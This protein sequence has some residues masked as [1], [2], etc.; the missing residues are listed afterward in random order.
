MFPL[1]YVEHLSCV[2]YGCHLKKGS[3]TEALCKRA[4]CY[5]EVVILIT[6][7]SKQL[8]TLVDMKK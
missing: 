4:T 7:I 1:E 6:I 3:L 5:N 2:M 8:I